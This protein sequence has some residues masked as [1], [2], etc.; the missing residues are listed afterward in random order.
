[1]KRTKQLISISMIFLLLSLC[2]LTLAQ[3]VT[4]WVDVSSGDGFSSYGLKSD[5][6]L[7]AWGDNEHGQLGHYS[8][9]A[10][11]DFAVQIGTDN[12]WASIA[13]GDDHC[14]AL[15]LDGTL[16]AWGDN[17]LGELGN[18]AHGA[19][20]HENFP[21]QIG[22]DHWLSIAASSRSSFGVKADGT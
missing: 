10:D 12:D 22:S 20:V 11:Q 13:P 14:L 17:S 8:N 9:G 7:W 5:G 3:S 6:T 4:N 2:K 21:I 15:K 18:G 16:W 1:M 19:T